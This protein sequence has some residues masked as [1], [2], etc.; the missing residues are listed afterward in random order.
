MI[1]YPP[2]PQP[3]YTFQYIKRLA[4]INKRLERVSSEV[5]EHEAF[6]AAQPKRQRV[7]EPTP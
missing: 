6:S 3:L 1:E 4:E 5:E 7:K 2:Q